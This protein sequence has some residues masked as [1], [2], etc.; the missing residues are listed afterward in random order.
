MA[1]I[2]GSATIQAKPVAQHADS[3]EML[4]HGGR[5]E[6]PL[7]FFDECRY[8]DRPHVGQVMQSLQLAP[9]RDP[10]RGI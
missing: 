2:R 4:F 8:V 1:K 7:Q 5:R 6:L 10:P 9:G 3:R